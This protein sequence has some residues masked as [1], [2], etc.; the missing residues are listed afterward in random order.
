MSDLIA[1]GMPAGTITASVNA[2]PRSRALVS[3]GVSPY[4]AGSSGTQE[5]AGWH[6]SLR[7]PDAEVL[8]SRDKVVAR[9]RDL[10]RNNPWING[11]V[12]K[13]ADAIVGSNIR[14]RAKPDFAAMGQSAEW[15]DEWSMK[16]EAMW[17]TWANDPRFL[18]DVERHLNFG[19][20][21][22]LAY[23]HWLLDGEA[24][25]VINMRERGGMFATCA[26]VLDPDRLSNPDGRPDDDTIRGGI[27]IDPETGAAV[28]Y[29]VRRSHPAEVGPN[30]NGHKW[31]RVERES[32]RGRPLFVH[33]INKRR[34]HQHRSVGAL[35][36]SMG[37][38]KNLDTYDRYELG[39]ALR[40]QAY[41]M[42]VESP[43][44]SEFVRQALAPAGEG[45]DDL[46]SEYQDMRL[47][48]HEA[49]DVSLQGVPLAHLAPGEQIKSVQST[50]PTTNYE[51]FTSFNL[52][53]VSSPFGLASEQ[54]TGRWAGVNYSNARMI[55]NEANRGWQSE[56]FSFTQAFCTP[57]Y[58]AV[59]EELVARD[60]IEVPGGKMM[61][62]VWRA[63][64][65]QAEWIGPARGSIDKL[66][67]GKGDEIDRLGFVGTLE[68]HCAE[69]GLD[70]RDVLYQRKR[71]LEE[72][73]RYGL[74]PDE[75]ATG[76]GGGGADDDPDPAADPNAD[77]RAEA[78][79]AA[80]EDE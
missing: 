23:I 62:Y 20:M 52:S 32:D 13:K 11:A 16:V 69:R 77:D 5:L 18:C 15:S 61:F 60:M 42:Y 59:L 54:V 46:L 37:R 65:T 76:N 26:L 8:P 45:G 25:A 47:A 51:A 29:H 44:D 63:A 34:A 4:H 64:L 38:M 72:M 21:V 56:R 43:F 2:V 28:A 50:N 41:G 58:A 14:L 53:A 71:E 74:T 73:R 30:W 24:C 12:T 67:E 3:L 35:T 33:A 79:E 57:I 27:E 40:N 80:G 55:V 1:G 31:T 39:A 49:T 19:G 68:A 75:A 9:S 6:P 17:R 48:F 10:D 36:P 70:W 78:R 7:S 22:K 66:K